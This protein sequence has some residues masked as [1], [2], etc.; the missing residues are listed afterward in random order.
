MQEFIASMGLIMN[1]IAPQDLLARSATGLIQTS[2]GRIYGYNFK[3]QIFYIEKEQLHVIKDW[4]GPVNGLATDDQGKVW[5]SA[6]NGCYSINDKN[7][8]L[9]KY[10]SN[11]LFY[12]K[13]SL[14]FAN[15]IRRNEE[16][17]IFFQ[18]GNKLIK[19]SNSGKENLFELNLKY[20]STTLIISNS[21]QSPW[22]FSYTE[23]SV[24]HPKKGLWKRYEDRRF[25]E[26]YNG[27]KVTA[28]IEIDN[29]LW[30]CTH[31]GIIRM[32]L[33]SGNCE[34]MY[35]TIPSRES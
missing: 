19:L 26:L 12:G 31:T 22:L 34:L 7:Q 9:E 1:T 24:Y 30:V 4:D 35:P 16:G 17:S 21:K 15:N 13:D 8:T 11:L 20:K 5:V 32:D 25:H 18:N 3:G 10:H 14:A 23:S 29:D 33:L 6:Q 28:A 2:S 27:R